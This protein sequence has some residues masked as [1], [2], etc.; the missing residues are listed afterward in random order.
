[1]IRTHIEQRASDRARPDGHVKRTGMRAGLC[2]VKGLRRLIITGQHRVTSISLYKE[3]ISV[4][5]VAT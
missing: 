1:M 3:K 5:V 2:L 4:T